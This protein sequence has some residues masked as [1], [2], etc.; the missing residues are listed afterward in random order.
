MNKKKCALC[1]KNKELRK[2]HI[3]PEFFYKP[4]Y[5]EKHR[6]NL[7]HLTEEQ[8]KKYNHMQ[9]GLREYL[10]CDDCENQI[11]RYENYVSQV[12][13]GGIELLYKNGNP[14]RI[15]GVDYKLFK[16]FQLS[17]LFLAS[18]S[19]LEF[20]KN[21]NLGPHEDKIR[22]MIIDENPGKKSEYPCTISIPTMRRKALTHDFIYEPEEL[23]KFENHRQYRF[24]LGGCSWIYMVSSHTQMFTF[25]E[26]FLDKKGILLIP[27]IKSD[28]FFSKLADDMFNRDQ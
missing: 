6:L 26:F 12:F 23:N 22:K 27:I 18:I 19:K 2:S 20:F 11:S 16:L 15:E 5:D 9:K 21:I 24:I 4:L 1:H 8:M 3:I 14:L 10:L 7:F 28:Q 17:L 13:Y 25:K